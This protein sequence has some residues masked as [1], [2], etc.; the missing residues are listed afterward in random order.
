MYGCPARDVRDV[1]L[2][3]WMTLDSW[4]AEQRHVDERGMRKMNPITEEQARNLVL[5]KMPT[6]TRKAVKT[7]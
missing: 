7:A 5:P 2:V 6:R 4:A 3:Y 1:E